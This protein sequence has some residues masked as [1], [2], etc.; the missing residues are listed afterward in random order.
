MI[1]PLTIKP[2]LF[3]LLKEK[4]KLQ[5]AKSL[6]SPAWVGLLY[7][8]PHNFRVKISL[9]EHLTKGQQKSTGILLT[10]MI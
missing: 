3:D 6:Q 5:V 9:H 7:Q 1:D 8:L 2:E 10:E 4:W